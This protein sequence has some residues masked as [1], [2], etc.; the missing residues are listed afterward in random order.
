MSFVP[1]AKSGLSPKSLLSHTSEAA[2][3]L[4]SVSVGNV[5]QLAIDALIASYGAVKVGS[6]RTPHVLP[7]VGADASATS[8]DELSG[9]LSLP[10]ELFYSEPQRVLLLQQRAPAVT[11]LNG[12]YAALLLSVLT[13]ELRVREVL[14]LT[15]ASSHLR[16]DS[17]IQHDHDAL[18]DTEGQEGYLRS[19]QSQ[20]QRRALRSSM[21]FTST[22]GNAAAMTAAA[23]LEWREL[24]RESPPP[25]PPLPALNDDDEDGRFVPSAS[26]SAAQRRSLCPLYP[27]AEWLRG[28]GVS[29]YLWPLLEAASARGSLHASALLIHTV[30]GD[31]ARDALLMAR[32]AD[33]FL[34]AERAQRK[35][36]TAEVQ[37]CTPLAWHFV[38]GREP[39]REIY[40]S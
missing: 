32:E 2:L 40:L 38:F 4:P 23:S 31:N 17:Q 39:Q 29:R 24:A 8:E 20:Q 27:F 34:R 26:S 37:W 6:I 12:P 16:S 33:A 35:E 3:I 36:G 18:T 21:H 1:Y 28:G 15:S 5:G 22:R 7:V 25:P 30:E 9:A 11:G 10:V 19:E 14:L 13:D